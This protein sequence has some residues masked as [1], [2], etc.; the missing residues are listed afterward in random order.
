MPDS[1][2]PYQRVYFL[3]SL[4]PL[5][6]YFGLVSNK[7]EP[8]RAYPAFP[9]VV[10]GCEGTLGDNLFD[11]GDFGAGAIN[12]PNQ[13]PGIAPGYN[14]VTFGPPNDGQYVIT[15]NTGAWSGL[16][17]TWIKIRDNSTDPN[18]YM[19]VVNADFSPGVFYEQEISE[20]YQY[21]LLEK[22]TYAFC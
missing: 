4:I 6:Y 16:Y 10:M 8:V 7:L 18:G 14:Y 3:I 19:M 9:T 11:D 2:P 12:I 21:N 22:Y 13:D 1:T 5:L 20:F 15:N 17:P